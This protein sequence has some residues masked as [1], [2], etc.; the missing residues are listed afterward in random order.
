MN[1]KATKSR[2][3]LHCYVSCDNE[4][5]IANECHSYNLKVKLVSLMN[6]HYSNDHF[7]TSF[8]S[9]LQSIQIFIF[10]FLKEEEEAASHWIVFVMLLWSLSRSNFCPLWWWWLLLNWRLS[11]TFESSTFTNTYPKTENS[12]RCILI[13]NCYVQIRY[14]TSPRRPIFEI[15]NS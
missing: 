8:W 5:N 9:L 4:K 11:S 14:V 7:L 2:R 12:W 1:F 6:G 15:E 10:L 3:K 13:A